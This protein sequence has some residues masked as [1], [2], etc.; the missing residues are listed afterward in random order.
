MP[1]ARV[2]CNDQVRH[3][4]GSR[5]HATRPERGA[6][7]QPQG[8][9]PVSHV[10]YG[11]T[12]ISP[13]VRATKAEMQARY[14]ALIAIAR[15][16]NPCTVR[17]VFYQASVRGI[18]EKT[19]DGYNKVQ[20][21][22]VKLRLSD[23][24]PF[25]WIVD[26]TR[27]RRKPKS[28]DSLEEALEDTAD[29]YRRKLWSDADAYVEVWL[30][31]DAL[32]GAIYP[33][34]SQYDVPLMTARGYSSI[35]FLKS[36]AEAIEYEDKPAYIYHLGDFDPSGVDAALNIERRLC[37]FASGADIHF[38]RLAVTER[39]IDQWRLPTRPTKASDTRAKKFGS[40]L[41]CELDAIEPRQLRRL[42]VSAIERHVD[43]DQL[44]TLREA[45]QSEKELLRAWRKSLPAGD[46]R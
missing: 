14:D 8:A 16:V 11:A 13:R 43:P 25:D 41:S 12:L 7:G 35:T 38:E 30:E 33:V 26:N 42:V 15:E 32:A 46:R 18:V 29:F 20:N 2:P 23:E 19:E 3:E 6:P 10:L 17:Q 34:T 24:I 4:R 39:Q 36:S 31:K 27:W 9:V 1:V 40:R 44:H 28:Y 45:E 5:R 37:E 22:L 21:A